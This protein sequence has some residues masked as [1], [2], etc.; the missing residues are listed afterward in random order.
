[1]TTEKINELKIKLE[2]E[3]ALLEKETLKQETGKLFQI[4]IQKKLIQST[5]Q[6][7]MKT[8]KKE[9]EKWKLWKGD[10]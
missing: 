6:I 3:K 1:M 4:L 5:K 10:F 8:S 9:R 7:E 2:E